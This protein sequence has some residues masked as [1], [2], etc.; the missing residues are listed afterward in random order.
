MVRPVGGDSWTSRPTASYRLVVT[1][2]A[3]S[4]NSTGWPVTRSMTVVVVVAA[5][6]PAA[7]VTVIV[8]VAAATSSVLT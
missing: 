1:W 2:P 6:V 7:A 4:V 5:F 8:R 3:P